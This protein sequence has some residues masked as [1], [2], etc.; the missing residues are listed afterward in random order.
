MK[1]TNRYQRTGDT[2]M[3]ELSIAYSL[4]DAAES[5]ARAHN[6]HKVTAVHLKLG[7]FSGVVKG[8]LLFGYDLAAKGTL[9]EGS[10]LEIEEVPVIVHCPAC[11]QDSLLPNVQLFACPLCGTPTADIRQGREIE[12]T[13]LEIIHDSEDRDASAERNGQKPADR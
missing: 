5:A 2:A 7:A 1:V 12:I 10:R 11:G 3:H 13:A 8:P 9:L 6:A 4:I